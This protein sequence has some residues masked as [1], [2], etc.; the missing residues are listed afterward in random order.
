[1]GGRE[2]GPRDVHVQCRR[3]EGAGVDSLF[4]LACVLIRISHVCGSIG[5]NGTSNF[6]VVACSLACP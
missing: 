4:V 2:K 6:T 1:M 3:V 5:K